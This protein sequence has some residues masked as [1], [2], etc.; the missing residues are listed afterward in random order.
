MEGVVM[1]KSK[2]NIIHVVLFADTIMKYFDEVIKGMASD[3]AYYD[4]L[5][6]SDKFLKNPKKEG[7]KF[8]ESLEYLL[9]IDGK[10][11]VKIV[12]QYRDK[13]KKDRSFIER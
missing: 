12:A 9:G 2:V 11:F 10:D 8:K 13:I 4:V 6:A 5:L 3:I 1:A 7:P